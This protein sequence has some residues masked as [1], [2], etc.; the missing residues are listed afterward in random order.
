MA[1]PDGKPYCACSTTTGGGCENGLECQA[2]ANG[3]AGCFCSPSN[4][5]GCAP[6]LL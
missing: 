1:G 3:F 4:Q 2:D 6:G 5:V